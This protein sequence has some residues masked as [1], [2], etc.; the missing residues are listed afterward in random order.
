MPVRLP[1]HVYF[2]AK[3][4]KM[5]KHDYTHT[6]KTGFTVTWAVFV[7]LCW[8]L[9]VVTLP[10]NRSLAELLITAE[11]FLPLNGPQRTMSRILTS[12]A[13]NRI[14]N[15]RLPPPP[16]WSEFLATD[17]EVRVRFPVLPD[18]LRNSGSRKGSTQP[19][20]Y[21]WPPLWPSDQSSWLQIHGSGFDS[22]RCQ[23]FWEVVGLERCPL[24][25]VSRTEKLLRRN[26]SGFGLENREYGRGNPMRWPRDTIR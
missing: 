5:I 10:G 24:S 7:L 17:P 18:F 15:R 2:V 16:L 13:N 11:L 14:L 3:I 8:F 12:V 26:S 9:V 21:N 19:R 25:L 1:L 6:W 22:R 20:E 4:R 23:I